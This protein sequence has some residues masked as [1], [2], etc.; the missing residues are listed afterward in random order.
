MIS[1]KLFGKKVAGTKLHI[2]KKEK[3]KISFFVLEEKYKKK[4]R[5]KKGGK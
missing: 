2:I 4:K 1:E 5:K 3:G